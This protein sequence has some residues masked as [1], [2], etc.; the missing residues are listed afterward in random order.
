MVSYFLDIDDR[1]HLTVLTQFFQVGS[2]IS[3]KV[4]IDLFDIFDPRTHFFLLKV[5]SFIHFLLD[6]VP[7]DN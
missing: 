5:H 1:Y 3:A 4:R 7:S 2:P 6:Y